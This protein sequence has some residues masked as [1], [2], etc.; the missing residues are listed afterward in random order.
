MYIVYLINVNINVIDHAFLLLV[1]MDVKFMIT[2]VF[3]PQIDSINRV[4]G[5]PCYSMRR[6]T[7]GHFYTSVYTFLISCMVIMQLYLITI[8]NKD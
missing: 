8:L 7:I 4:M 6:A 3:I 2:R 1:N 5:K